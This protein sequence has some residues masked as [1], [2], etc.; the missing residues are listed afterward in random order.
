MKERII[1][2]NYD[3]WDDYEEEARNFLQEEYP[4]I[5]I[6]ENDIWDEIN[7]QDQICWDDT[8]DEL[9]RFFSKYEH[10]MLMGS[11]GLWTGR[12]AAGDIFDSFQDAFYKATKDCDYIKIWDENGHLYLQCSHHDGTNLFEIKIINDK[13]FEFIENW[14]YNWDDKRQKKD[15]HNIVWNSNFLSKLPHYVYT[16]YGYRKYEN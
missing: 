2:N 4:D 13:G 11:L 10:I 8:Y 16:T 5:E 3:L 6:T 1:Y 9:T 7:F 12:H 14:S 15:I